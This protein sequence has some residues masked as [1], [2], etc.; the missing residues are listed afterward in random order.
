MTGLYTLISG[1]ILALAVGL[2]YSTL[3]PGFERRIHARLQQR[4]GP[5]I[6]TPGFW[7]ILKFCCKK[8]MRP[9]SPKPKWLHFF[10]TVSFMSIAFVFLFT[11]PCWWS[12]LGLGTIFAVMGLLKIEEAM[13]LFMGS[14]SRNVMSAM[15]FPDAIHGARLRDTLKASFEEIGAMRALKM[16]SLGS[17]PLYIALLVPF[18][19]TGSLM[20]EDVIASQNPSYRIILSETVFQQIM[21]MLQNMNPTI[22][23][24]GG[25]IGAFV[26]F[27]GYVISTKNRP[28][29]IIKPKVDII[30]G[31]VMEY[32]AVWR[33]VYFLLN[34]FLSFT[35]SSIFVA[36]YF[37]VPFNIQYPVLCAIH[38]IMCLIL[39]F[40]AAVLRAFSPVFNFK[41][42]YFA[43]IW[44]T[45]LGV[46]ALMLAFV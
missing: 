17:F 26:Y 24:A 16:I 22:F 39:P 38:L 21:V 31:P 7:S 27:I 13:Y 8:R 9:N 6:A 18:A 10:L 46:V 2:V 23:T 33:G 5:P 29:D 14:I 32:N 36:F 11:T 34:G 42:I 44:A 3:I 12:I 1:S 30:E 28:F 20:I 25:L 37:G 45:V 15:R 43:S 35:L 19:Y 41:Q 40:F 4:I